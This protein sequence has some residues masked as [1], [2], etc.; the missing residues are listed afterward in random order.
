MESNVTNWFKTSSEQGGYVPTAIMRLVSEFELMK[1]KNIYHYTDVTG[2]ISIMQKQELWASHISFMNDNLEF[3][4]GQMLFK[5][6]LNEAMLAGSPEEK[7][8]LSQVIGAL[9]K[10]QSE[11]LFSK[12]SKDVFS[13]SFSYND[14][15][16]EMWRGYGKNCGIAIGFDRE[17]LMSTRHFCLIRKESYEELLKVYGDPQ[18]ICPDHEEGFYPIDVL[19]DD[20]EKQKFIENVISLGLKYFNNVL[21]ERKQTAYIAGTQ[22]F[23]DI[24]FALIPFLKHNSF[25]SEKECRLIHNSVDR[26]NKESHKIYFRERGGVILPYIIYKL[27][28]GNCQPLK[29]LPIHKIIVGPGLK[30]KKVVESVKYFLENNSMHYLIDKVHA[31]SIP[32]MEV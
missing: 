1:M 10:K 14:D 2:F 26:V 6:A 27:V 19:Y 20:M 15:S 31:S 5:Q 21:K 13:L 22:F 23:T 8:L 12:S 30:Q 4:H 18:K 29:E 17:H 9:D 11:G 16:L 3:L 7:S 28:D 25:K 24:I 32:Y